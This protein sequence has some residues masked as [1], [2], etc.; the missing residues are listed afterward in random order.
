MATKAAKG[1]TP[2]EGEAASVWS[3]EPKPANVDVPDWR[4]QTSKTIQS[5]RSSQRWAHQTATMS[6][7]SHETARCDNDRKHGKVHNAFMDKIDRSKHLVEILAERVKSVEASITLTKLSCAEIMEAQAAKKAPLQLCLKRLEMRARLLPKG[8]R[9]RDDVEFTLREEKET[10]EKSQALLIEQAGK[11]DRVVSELVRVHEDLMEDLK[12]KTHSLHI[13]QDCVQAARTMGMAT[14]HPPCEEPAS[15]ECHRTPSGIYASHPET[16][17]H[18]RQLE[19][20][21]RTRQAKKKEEQA[22]AVREESSR[23]MRQTSNNCNAAQGRSRL[24]LDKSISEVRVIIDKLKLAIKNQEALI[25]KTHGSLENTSEEMAIHEAPF[26]LA[27]T[28][29]TLRQ[30]KKHSENIRDPVRAALDEQVKALKV[31][32]EQLESRQADEKE[33]LQDLKATLKKLKADLENKNQALDADMKLREE[34]SLEAMPAYQSPDQSK[35][36]MFKTAAS[37]GAGPDGMRGASKVALGAMMSLK[38]GTYANQHKW[39]EKLAD[40]GLKWQP[41]SAR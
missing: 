3:G 21:T 38:I 34:C 29:L 5:A 24:A 4:Q 32:Q 12:V 40:T 27:T 16:Q 26:N 33:A 31:N 1:T 28:R 10:L 14:F 13:D 39:E 25:S 18:R 22:D 30:Q 41:K 35:K 19:T 23:L 9:K 7:I 2:S 11:A 6:R 17:E 15:A 36:M 20:V 37:F 8:E